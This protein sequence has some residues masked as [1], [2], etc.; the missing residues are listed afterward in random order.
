[1]GKGS[2]KN[3]ELKLISNI[4]PSHLL[5][6]MIQPSSWLMNRDKKNPRSG[7]DCA[8][9]D[10]GFFS[11][12]LMKHALYPTFTIL[13]LTILFCFIRLITSK[14]RVPISHQATRE[15][16][17][18]SRLYPHRRSRAF[19]AQTAASRRRLCLYR[20]GHLLADL[21]WVDLDLE[22]SIILPGQ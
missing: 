22:C 6:L 17:I 19:F 15:A 2:S 21:G 7:V 8:P 20:V 4:R 16:P 12:L 18:P 14:L 13:F 10:R 3:I 11:W 9:P 5:L 1:M